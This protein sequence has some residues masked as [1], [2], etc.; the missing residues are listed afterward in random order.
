[1]P[2][3]IKKNEKILDNVCL[4]VSDNTRARAYLDLLTK[5]G[6]YPSLAIYLVT[7]NIAKTPTILQEN[8]LFDNTT[9]II[10]ALNK[11]DIPTIS[12]ETESLNSEEVIKVTKNLKQ[13]IIIFAGPA[14]GLLTENFFTSGK[15]FLH[16]HPGK[17][18][19]YRGST[20]MYYS[21][22]NENNITVTALFLNEKIDQGEIIQSKTFV[23]I[24]DKTLIDT[25]YDP[26]FRA[27]VIKDVISNYTARGVI[28]SFPQE[29]NKGET[30]CI[31]HPLLKHIAI[32]GDN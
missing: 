27:V 6:L 4:L 16:A 3:I 20:P 31:I 19:E 21:L 11:H 15:K 18:P 8:N 10:E 24:E 30:Y 17:L 26:Y 2:K 22:I 7:S 1:M 5:E 14:G 29:T 12:I 32:L 9:P 25:V 23:E 13:D 28:E